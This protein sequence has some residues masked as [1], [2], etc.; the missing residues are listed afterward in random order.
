[1]KNQTVF[2]LFSIIIFLIIA[3]YLVLIYFVPSVEIYKRKPNTST[4]RDIVLLSSI[5]NSEANPKDKKDMYLIGSTVLNRLDNEGYP[6]TILDVISQSGQYDGYMTARFNRSPQSD[7]V[8]ID[9]LGG[10]GRDYCVL[11]FYNPRTATDTKFI[12]AINKQYLLV[13]STTSH[14]F[15]GE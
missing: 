14:L 11:F 12:N 6:T 7:Y 9:L 5:I 3:Y 2:A 13:D 8:A 1:M 4:Y 10:I 15:F